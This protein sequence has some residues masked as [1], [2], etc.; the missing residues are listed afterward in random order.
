[1]TL[2]GELKLRWCFL[3]VTASTGCAALLV[4]A[5]LGQI[6]I[7]ALAIGLVILAPLAARAISREFDIF[8]PL[9]WALAALFVMFVIRPLAVTAYGAFTFRS[10]YDLAPLIAP[11]LNVALIGCASFVLGYFLPVGARLAQ[12]L[13]PARET[14]APDR[15]LILSAVLAFLGVVGYAIFA[16][17]EGHS[18]ADIARGGLHGDATSTAYFYYAPYILIPAGLLLYREG[19]LQQSIKL[20]FAGVVCVLPL[21]NSL[22]GAGERVWLLVIVSAFAVYSYLRRGT[23]PRVATVAIVVLVGLVVVVSLRD[24]TFGSSHDSV[25]SSIHNTMTAPSRAARTF[26]T[27]ADTEMLSGLALEVGAVPRVQSYEPGSAV[28]TFLSHPMPRVL[29]PNKPR[30]AEDRLN[31][32]FFATQGY[33]AGEPGVSYSLLGGLYFDS[34][35]LGVAIGMAFIGVM[36]RVLFEYFRRYEQNDAVRLLYAATLPFV[37]VLMRGNLQDT[38][39]RMLFVVVPAYLV[40]RWSAR[41]QNVR[42]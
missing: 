20:R 4:H 10:R 13:A 32:R 29:W 42:T 27:D 11:A 28:T 40:L 2:V 39:S 30:Q 7:R 38:V 3:C 8:E 24:V 41:G 21:V 6:Q 9:V 12:R 14:S 18:V 19:L 1:M 23:R 34:G 15:V 17:R 37:V 22:T 5:Q 26:L 33:R 36:L 31:E 25:G 35:V 16:S